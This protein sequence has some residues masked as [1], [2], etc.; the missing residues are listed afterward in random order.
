MCSW[1]LVLSLLFLASHSAEVTEM[2]A[3]GNKYET[4]FSSM[5]QILKSCGVELS[6]E[7]LQNICENMSFYSSEFRQ[8]G[9]IIF[10]CL[11]N[12]LWIEDGRCDGIGKIGSEYFDESW[13][14]NLR[15]E[16][17]NQYTKYQ[18]TLMSFCLYY[19]RTI[20]EELKHKM[21]KKVS[22]AVDDVKTRLWQS[23]NLSS[24]IDLSRSKVDTALNLMKEKTQIM[25]RRQLSYSQDQQKVKSTIANVQKIISEKNI[26]NEIKK[27]S[28]VEFFLG[29][30]VYLTLL[31]L[32][33]FLHLFNISDIFNR[34]KSALFRNLLLCAIVSFILEHA[35]LTVSFGWLGPL[36]Y[37]LRLLLKLITLGYYLKSIQNIIWSRLE[38]TRLKT[39]REVEENCKRIHR[40]R[41]SDKSSW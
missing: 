31:M 6:A 9:N 40:M 39:L 16:E 23:T 30:Q 26:N 20:S 3:L 15:P 19:T 32:F 35:N 29:L 22:E 7:K 10:C 25:Q 12:Q 17:T 27:Y 5:L 38:M 8:F 2:A 4:S 33:T 28:V 1:I 21:F 36:G 34:H 18:A 14:K 41:F 37:R 13:E 24:T 11:K